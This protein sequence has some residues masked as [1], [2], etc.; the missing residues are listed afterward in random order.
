MWARIVEFILAIWIVNSYCVFF[1]PSP[2]EFFWANSLLCGSLV[3]IFALFSCIRR[4]ER[5]H[6]CSLVVALW[7]VLVGFF[8]SSDFPPPYALQNYVIVGLLLGMFAI[9]PSRSQ[10]PPRAWEAFYK[11]KRKE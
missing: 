11:K 9:V 1:C 2:N 7:L 8:A 3:A 6:L 5:L 10:K 4:F